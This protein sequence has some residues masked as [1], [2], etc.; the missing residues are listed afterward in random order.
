M[1]W[2]L[3]LEGPK[4]SVDEESSQTL[5]P[6]DQLLMFNKTTP[7]SDGISWRTPSRYSCN[8]KAV[9]EGCRKILV[10]WE[11]DKTHIR[12]SSLCLRRWEHYDAGNVERE[13]YTTVEKLYNWPQSS[14]EGSYTTARGHL[15]L[16]IP[17]TKPGINVEQSYMNHALAKVCKRYLINDSALKEFWPSLSLAVKVESYSS[18]TTNAKIVVHG[19]DLCTSLQSKVT[20]VFNLNL[21][22]I[23]KRTEIEG[24][25]RIPFCYIFPFP[26]LSKSE[27][28]AW[29]MSMMMSLISSLS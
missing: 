6:A 9:K 1:S 24:T 22:S 8:E 29:S 10:Y 17:H 27:S 3:I 16:R 19:D 4:L 21:P 23:M 28:W 12:G 11:G 26:D 15:S 25:K 7:S 20:T 18:I 5:Q 13:Q 2:S 14:W